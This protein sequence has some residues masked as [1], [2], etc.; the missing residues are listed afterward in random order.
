MFNVIHNSEAKNIIFKV[1]ANEDTLKY[2]LNEA[3]DWLHDNIR[4]FEMI[5]D[6]K[7]AGHDVDAFAM[8][9]IQSHMNN[10]ANMTLEKASM[11]TFKLPFSIELSNNR[12]KE[13]FMLNEIYVTVC[14]VE[15]TCEDKHIVQPVYLDVVTDVEFTLNSFTWLK[16]KTISNIIT[17]VIKE[18]FDSNLLQGC[19]II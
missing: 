10:R 1:S 6:I 9:L 2:D 7:T 15:A 17:E 5:R 19:N 11:E 13:K 3:F 16:R 4:W 14:R 8:F 12:F 18:R